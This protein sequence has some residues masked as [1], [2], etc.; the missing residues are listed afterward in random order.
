MERNV[1]FRII[2][3]PSSVIENLLQSEGDQIEEKNNELKGL[4]IQYSDIRFEQT[5]V[6]TVTIL[7]VDRMQSLAIEKTDDSKL[8]FMEAI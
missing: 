8:D 6:T 3:P 2:T 1:R 5:A 7:V 4:E